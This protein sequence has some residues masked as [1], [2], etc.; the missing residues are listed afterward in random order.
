VAAETHCFQIKSRA[1]VGLRSHRAL[2]FAALYCTPPAGGTPLQGAGSPFTPGV[3]AAAAAAA[4]A[5]GL[6]SAPRQF[7]GQSPAEI[8]AT[9]RAQNQSYEDVVLQ[10]AN[11]VS[12]GGVAGDACGGIQGLEERRRTSS[13]PLWPGNEQH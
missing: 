8:A 1:T 3:A 4:A 7:A 9:L 5:G 10:L 11:A 2:P 13:V 6:G 12:A